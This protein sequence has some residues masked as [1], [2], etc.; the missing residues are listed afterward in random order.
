[1][2]KKFGYSLIVAGVLM[3]G[4]GVV[5]SVSVSTAMAAEAEE[6]AC[7]KCKD[8]PSKPAKDCKCACHTPAPKK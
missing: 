3:L 2:L 4:V 7:D 1:M 5:N 6:K 8:L